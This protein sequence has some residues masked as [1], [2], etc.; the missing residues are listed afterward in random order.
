M[1]FLCE[2]SVST[3]EGQLQTLPGPGMTVQHGEPAIAPTRSAVT[4]TGALSRE[5]EHDSELPPSSVDH[6][7]TRRL[8]VDTAVNDGSAT[9]LSYALYEALVSSGPGGPLSPPVT[10][11]AGEVI[12]DRYVIEGFLGRGGM[13]EVYAAFDRQR[14]QRVALKTVQATAGDERYAIRCLRREAQL[15]RRVHHANV[16]RVFGFGVDATQPLDAI[17]YMTME[18]LDGTCLRTR[19]RRGRLMPCEALSIARQVLTALD[20]THRAQVLHRDVKSSNVMVAG[21]GAGIVA[22]LLDFGLARRLN[23]HGTVARAGAACS[24]GYVAPEQ[25]AGQ[26]QSPRADI[27]SFGVVLYEIL[28]ESLSLE[29]AS[30]GSPFDDALSHASGSEHLAL[31]QTLV[32]VANRCVR[33]VA[34]E[35]Y[36]SAKEALAALDSCPV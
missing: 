6:H 5:R 33:Q 14:A 25:L 24:L 26:N 28:T 20:A 29:C 4:Q 34:A 23:E 18:L 22:T 12:S 1:E 10:F 15:A 8:R 35:R 16:C 13:G 17:Y 27:F 11:A 32:A 21:A 2:R 9:A 30:P 31:I 3:V 19:L 36:A 7:S